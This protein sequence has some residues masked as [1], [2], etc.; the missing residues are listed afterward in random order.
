[1]FDAVKHD[2]A[3]Q[4]AS[5]QSRAVRWIECGVGDLKRVGAWLWGM[6]PSLPVAVAILLTLLTF[7]VYWNVGAQSEC[8]FGSFGCVSTWDRFWGSS[9]NEMG[10][11]LAG[12]SGGLVLIWVVASVFMQNRELRETRKEVQDQRKATEAM[13]DAMKE[14]SVA[15]ETMARAMERQAEVAKAQLS[16]IAFQAK[17]RREARLRAQFEAHLSELESEVLDEVENPQKWTFHHRED[18]NSIIDSSF[19]IFPSKKATPTKALM[20]VVAAELIKSRKYLEKE[21]KEKG[22][23]KKPQFSSRIK[24]M[25]ETLSTILF[26]KS[27]LAPDQRTKIN[28]LHLESIHSELKAIKELPIWSEDP[29]A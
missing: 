5:R 24:R 26:M 8:V 11:T 27:N 13:A 29:S 4:E 12:L 17:E 18:L 21:Q 3:R 19:K 6:R 1:M 7:R 22:L 2:K 15:T 28:E 20:R 16:E 10:D 23:F 14:Q 9:P 25:I